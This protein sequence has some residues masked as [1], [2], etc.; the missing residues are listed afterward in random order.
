[1]STRTRTAPSWGGVHR[2]RGRTRGCWVVLCASVAI[3]CGG[4]TDDAS[5]RSAGQGGTPIGGV[6]GGTSSGGSSDGGT[7]TKSGGRN[8]IGGFA[9][10]GS[11]A[12]GTSSG[13]D[14]TSGR[15]SGGSATG[16]SAGAYSSGGTDAG[17]ASTGGR[18]TSPWAECTDRGG[19]CVFMPLEYSCPEGTYNPFAADT[20]CPTG[21]FSRCCVPMGGLGSPCDPSHPCAAGGGCLGEASG[22]PRGGEC[23]T[24]C[25]GEGSC[26]AWQICVPVMW[27]EAPGNCVTA[28]QSTA[29]CREGW[30]CQGF[31][32]DSQT[33]SRETV[34]ACWQPTAVTG[35]GLGD[36]C[37]EHLECL[38][39]LCVP[40]GPVSR[41]S[42]TCDD[43]RRCV[44]GFVCTPGSTCTSPGCGFCQP[45]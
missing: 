32:K 5:R 23:G 18:A 13:G 25:F 12:A 37:L 27:S 3:A 22:Y 16:G 30:S 39:R 17:G 26:P 24:A 7:G 10:G 15:P 28:C 43:T 34:Y 35:K 40:D 19:Q 8:S 44:P 38:S 1:M 45:A 9:M 41:C 6:L 2:D 11:I 36:G 42:A 4:E 21:S 29:M 33:P 14:A 31:A 20:L